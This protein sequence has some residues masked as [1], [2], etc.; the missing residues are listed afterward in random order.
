MKA[1]VCCSVIVLSGILLSCSKPAE[2][3]KASSPKVKPVKKEYIIESLDITSTVVVEE[4]VPEPKGYGVTV[5]DDE[6]GEPVDH[7]VVNLKWHINDGGG[8]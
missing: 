3:V 4:E 8:V 7:A 6:T 1:R 5:L 2:T